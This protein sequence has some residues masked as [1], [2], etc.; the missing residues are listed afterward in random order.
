MENK[1]KKFKILL[2]ITGS[3]SAYKSAELARLLTKG[4]SDNNT[5]E[6]QISFD[7]KCI[8]TDSAEKFVGKTLFEAITGN[9][10]LDSSWESLWENDDPKKMEHIT[11]ADW[12]DLLVIAPCTAHTLG[13]IAGGLGNTALL[14]TVLA[15]KSPL[16]IAPAMNVNMW[17]NKAVQENLTRLKNR[18]VQIIEPSEGELACGW[19]G[20]GRLAEPKDIYQQIV[21]ICKTIKPKE[22]ITKNSN[23]TEL[24]LSGR[25]VLISAGA[26]REPIDDVRFITNR[27]SGKM[28]VALANSALELGANVI[29][30][31]GGM[32]EV[33]P[34]NVTAF[35]TPTAD[36]MK[37][38]IVSL[39]FE[40]D[41]KNNTSD[42]SIIIMAAAVA[43]FKVKNRFKGKLKKTDG[44]PK[45]ELE[46][47]CDILATL[48]E[49]KQKSTEYKPT[50]VGFAVESTDEEG[51]IKELEKKI[52]AKKCD[53]LVGNIAEE[54]FEGDTNRVWVYN[55]KGKVVAI[56]K[57]SKMIIAEKIWKIIT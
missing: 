16:V 17:E 6:S 54:A 42:V 39:T 2:A 23:Q 7:V 11:V 43:D 15:C 45:I 28:G 50:I 8:L 1:N 19:N 26:T 51:I 4:N 57:A 30:V 55:K 52:K 29:L 25:T 35:Y 10:V 32:T 41:A 3:V 18:G 33:V 53:M 34:K 47:N 46:A 37:D 31:H 20:S 13:A 24:P 48:G 12:C 21:N 27:S 49:L 36:E 40:N 5:K 22:Q 56:E 38:K 9:P 44:I 14:A